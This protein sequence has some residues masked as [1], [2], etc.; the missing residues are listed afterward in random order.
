MKR[1]KLKT[2]HE[3][4][5]YNKYWNIEDMLMYFKQPWDF[6][7]SGISQYMFE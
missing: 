2:I 3:Y 7:V 1:L 4:T 5:L 6:D